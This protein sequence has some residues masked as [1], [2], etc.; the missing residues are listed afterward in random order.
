MAI[1]DKYITEIRYKPGR[2]LVII[3]YVEERDEGTYTH[4]TQGI[5][6]QEIAEA[7]AIPAEQWAAIDAAVLKLSGAV[8]IAPKGLGGSAR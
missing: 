1:G 2:D 6:R 5:A 7:A 4:Q 8:A 3:D